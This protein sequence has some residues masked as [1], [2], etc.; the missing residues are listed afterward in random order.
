MIQKL[1]IVNATNVMSAKNK[2]TKKYGEKYVMDRVQLKDAS[3]TKFMNKYQVY[4][5]KRKK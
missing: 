2:A 5:H 4:G 1:G 3:T